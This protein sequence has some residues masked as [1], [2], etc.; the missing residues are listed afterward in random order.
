[1]GDALHRVRADAVPGRDH[2][3]AWAMLPAQ[4]GLDSALD[5]GIDLGPPELLAVFLGPPQ[6]ARTR[7]W[8]IARSNSA[9]TPI[10]WNIA[11]PAGVVVS[12]PCWCRNRSMP[13]AHELMA[14]SGHKTLTEVQRYT[15]DAGSQ[16]ARR[17]RHG[18]AAGS[19]VYNVFNIQRHLIC[20]R[21]LRVFRDQAMQIWRQATPRSST[22]QREPLR[23]REPFGLQNF[24]LT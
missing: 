13:T 11:L 7:S 19:G 17:F 4:I 9:N 18:E 8:I 2:A 15:T 24:R 3:H 20:R 1:M 10:I 22:L 23:D 12:R 21:T 6:A 14:F 5:L 16:E